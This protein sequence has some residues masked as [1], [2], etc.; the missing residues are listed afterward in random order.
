[1]DII[2]QIG[3]ICENSLLFGTIDV[4]IIIIVAIIIIIPCNYWRRFHNNDVYQVDIAE[5]I[6]TSYCSTL[7]QPTKSQIAVQLWCIL[8]TICYITRMRRNN[9][10]GQRHRFYL[11]ISYKI[12]DKPLTPIYYAHYPTQYTKYKYNRHFAQFVRYIKRCAVHQ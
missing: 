6:W 3:R 5:C 1:M 10:C 4:S 2:H 11:P 9:K 12:I 7:K 8:Y